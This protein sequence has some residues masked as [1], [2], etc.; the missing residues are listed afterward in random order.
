LIELGENIALS[1][2]VLSW[3]TCDITIQCVDSINANPPDISWELIIIDNASTDGSPGK[4]KEKYS[5]FP[6]IRI[7]LNDQNL[8]FTGG[9]NQGLD[10]A[11]GDI[12]GLLNS[13]TIVKKN[14]LT[15]LYRYLSENNSAGVV[16][17][18]LIHE[19]GVPTTSFG[20]FPNVWRIFT[21]AF[22]PGWIWGNARK[23]LGV[24]PDSSMREPMGVDYVSGAAFFVKREVIDKVGKFDAET[25]F[26][27]F[28]ETD[29][30]LRIRKAGWQV[31]FYPGARIIHLEGK[32]FEK[33]TAHRRIMQY[34]SA[35]KFLRKHYSTPTVLWY[36]FCT[37]L[38]SLVKVA[39][40]GLRMF[41]QPARRERWLPHYKWNT[42]VFELWKKGLNPPKETTRDIT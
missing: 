2:I 31:I 42:F 12:I 37:V 14:A 13:D 27:Y 9:N 4:L 16:G 15:K 19:N 5:S 25:F 22:L 20:Y 32:S 29:W 34:D 39:Y 17:P 26:A 6:H 23:A 1:L 3:N 18:T 24:V 7:I 30:C 33:M 35:K 41:L 38:G 10:L 21:T 8:G 36:Q 11:Q 28:E 40:F